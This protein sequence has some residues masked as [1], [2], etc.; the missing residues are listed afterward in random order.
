LEPI[1]YVLQ[2][3]PR[4]LF[5]IITIPKMTT[6][7]PTVPQRRWLQP[8]RRVSLVPGE[9]YVEPGLYPLKEVEQH[10][11]YLSRPVLRTASS[12]GKTYRGSKGSMEPTAIAGKFSRAFLAP[13]GEVKTSLSRMERQANEIASRWDVRRY[14]MERKFGRQVT[15]EEILNYPRR[16]AERASTQFGGMLRQPSDDVRRIAYKLGYILEVA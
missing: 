7:M 13:P 10:M 3:P 14:E 9:E 11:K 2:E 5:N 6:P 12:Y 1:F 4:K 16:V 8:I 15:P